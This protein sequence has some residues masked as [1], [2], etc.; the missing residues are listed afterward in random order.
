MIRAL[1][2]AG[3]VFASFMLSTENKNNPQGGLSHAD[4]RRFSADIH[5]VQRVDKPCAGCRGGHRVLPVPENT[6]DKR[7]ACRMPLTGA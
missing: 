3:D 4:S 2:Y 5:D 1:L 7:K 6:F